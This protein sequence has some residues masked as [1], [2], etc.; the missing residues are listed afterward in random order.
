LVL[1]DRGARPR[2]RPH[3]HCCPTT[4]RRRRF[5]HHLRT[6]YH[7]RNDSHRRHSGSRH[8]P[9]APSADRCHRCCRRCCGRLHYS[10]S[11]CGRCRCCHCFSCRRRY[12]RWLCGRHPGYR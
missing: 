5:C 2:L 4:G 7:P 3:R 10:R 8:R 12:S 9:T 11:L 6:G 1:S